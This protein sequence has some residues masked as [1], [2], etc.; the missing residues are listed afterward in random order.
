[1]QTAQNGPA[2]HAGVILVP[3]T[4][5]MVSETQQFA[6]EEAAREYAAELAERRGRDTVVFQVIGTFTAVR[7]AIWEPAPC[8]G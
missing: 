7:G 5:P 4:P 1:M 6:T 3:G 8:I 2:F